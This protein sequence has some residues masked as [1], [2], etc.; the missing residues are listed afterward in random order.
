MRPKLQSAGG[1][2][3]GALVAAAAFSAPAPNVSAA[4]GAGRYRRD[5]AGYV[6]RG[7]F[8]CIEFSG[9]I[10]SLDPFPPG[11]KQ[12]SGLAHQQMGRQAPPHRRAV[13]AQ[14]SQKLSGV[15]PRL[16]QRARRCRFSICTL[17]LT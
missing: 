8:A 3:F 5:L 9:V 2:I 1:G 12:W 7:V 11:S 10:R 13:A 14:V 4:D 17:L 16:F 6:R 15:A